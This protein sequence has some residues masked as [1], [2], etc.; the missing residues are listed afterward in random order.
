MSVAQPK[1][2]ALAV[3]PGFLLD[4]R[5]YIKDSPHPQRYR[6]ELARP[7]S[8][9]AP[10]P[11]RFI[12]RQCQHKKKAVPVDPV[13]D[14]CRLLNPK[15]KIVE[16]VGKDRVEKSCP[17]CAVKNHIRTTYCK[18]CN[19]KLRGPPNPAVGRIIRTSTSARAS[20]ARQ[21]ANGYSSK[22]ASAN[23]AA[24]AGASGP[25]AYLWPRKK[26]KRRASGKLPSES[27]GSLLGRKEASEFGNG[28]PRNIG[29]GI[30]SRFGAKKAQDVRDARDTGRLYYGYPD[31]RGVDADV[32]RYNEFSGQ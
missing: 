31:P 13:M 29:A 24:A 10:R 25:S 16:R 21:R 11:L 19:Y 30:S 23:L 14:I 7:T 12:D 28:R 27:L 18:N 6:P 9:P 17:S 32:Y 8:P 4:V 22:A 3:L 5:P 20:A 26:D 1:R 2:A 15:K